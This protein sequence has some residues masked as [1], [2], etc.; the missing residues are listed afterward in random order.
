M[1]LFKLKLYEN[2]FDSK[3]AEMLFI[4][5]N[6]NHVIN[7][8]LNKK[9]LYNSFYAFLIKKALNFMK[10]FLILNCIREFFNF[11]EALILF[12]FKKNNSLRLY[13]NY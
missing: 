11:A 5:E 10:L 8:K 13:I 12:I 1:L 7:L 6:E 4:H 2:Y 3:N 9:F